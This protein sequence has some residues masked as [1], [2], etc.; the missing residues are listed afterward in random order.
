M[1]KG[2]G[3]DCCGACSCGICCG[4]FILLAGV[5]TWACV[6]GIEY[7][8]NV[9]VKTLELDLREIRVNI[10]N[11]NLYATEF[12]EFDLRLEAKAGNKIRINGDYKT[13]SVT[14]KPQTG[15]RRTLTRDDDTLSVQ[16]DPED[17]AKLM[18]KCEEK[19]RLK[20]KM[21]GHLK[22]RRAN[23]G[24]AK[25]KT[26]VISQWENVNCDGVFYTSCTNCLEG[27]PSPTGPCQQS[28]GLCWALDGEVCPTGTTLC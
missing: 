27:S 15:K 9:N 3:P 28:N 24:E 13:S 19:G 1:G 7:N 12:S 14:I 26:R 22:Q 11:R 8:P 4:V 18:R 6:W 23:S 10:Y 2:R 20:V 16:L 25:K 21:K 17:Y 5:V